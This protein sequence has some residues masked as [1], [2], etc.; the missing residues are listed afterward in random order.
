MNP[1]D[2]YKPK[3]QWLTVVGFSKEDQL[4]GRDRIGLTPQV[5][6]KV[7]TKLNEQLDPL[8]WDKWSPQFKRNIQLIAG[9]VI[10]IVAG[11]LVLKIIKVKIS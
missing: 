7:M 8:N 10:I 6:K 9:L 11:I 1:F 5:T 3:A 4:A 2:E